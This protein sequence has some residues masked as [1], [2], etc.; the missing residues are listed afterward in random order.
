MSQFPGV[1]SPS[2]GA[3]GGDGCPT[4]TR[5]EARPPGSRAAGLAATS[6]ARDLPVSPHYFSG[7]D[8]P[9]SR[10]Y[11]DDLVAEAALDGFGTPISPRHRR[12]Q[13]LQAAFRFGLGTARR[14]GA[15]PA[16]WW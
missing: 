6:S 12:D 4:G 1:C 14:S 3:P 2:A 10:E 11:P 8:T 7:V 5:F 9:L 13:L 16:P 15:G